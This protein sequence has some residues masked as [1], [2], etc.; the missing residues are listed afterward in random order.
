MTWNNYIQLFMPSVVATA[1]STAII[2][3]ITFSHTSFFVLCDISKSFYIG[4]NSVKKMSLQVSTN[5][6]SVKNL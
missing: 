3:L 5:Y 2:I 4:K 6:F 1:E